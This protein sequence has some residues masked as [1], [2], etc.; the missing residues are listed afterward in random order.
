[1]NKIENDHNNLI[2]KV[3]GSG[4][5]GEAH[6]AVKTLCR[7]PPCCS[8]P[9][10]TLP[11]TAL[12]S[13]G[14]SCAPAHRHPGSHQ[15]APELPGALLLLNCDK[16]FKEVGLCTHLIQGSRNHGIIELFKL[17]KT[18]GM[19]SMGEAEQKPERVRNGSWVWINGRA[20][21]TPWR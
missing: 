21:S 4:R 10:P 11:G 5:T 12:S 17:E 15:G 19:E 14:F 3:P 7:K 18:P 16:K 9:S 1:M 13:L 8:T 20:T 2:A 6:F